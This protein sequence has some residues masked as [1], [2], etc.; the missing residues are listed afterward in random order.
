MVVFPGKQRLS[1]SPVEGMFNIDSRMAGSVEECREPFKASTMKTVLS[2]F[3]NS[4]N[5]IHVYQNTLA[6]FSRG[7]YLHMY[8]NFFFILPLV[9]SEG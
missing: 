5:A 8:K 9:S 2:K 3:D 1:F 4:L 7:T 6:L